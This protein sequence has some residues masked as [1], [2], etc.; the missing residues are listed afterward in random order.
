MVGLFKELRIKRSA[1]VLKMEQYTSQ[2][3]ITISRGLLE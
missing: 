2:D 3:F 1:E